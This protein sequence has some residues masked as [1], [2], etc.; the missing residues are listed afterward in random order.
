MLVLDVTGPVLAN[1]T[2]QISVEGHANVLPTKRYPT[3][4]ELSSDRAT[5]VLRRLA[6]QG[7]VEPTRI[8]AVGFGDA[9]PLV[10]T[11][12]LDAL[13]ANRRVDLVVLSGVPDEVRVLLPSIAATEG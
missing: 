7:H 12:G 4:W 5:Q 8:A 11:G 9:R 10:D 6:E 3:N 2:D 1:L 13:D